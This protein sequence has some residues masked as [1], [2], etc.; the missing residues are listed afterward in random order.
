MQIKT[1]TTK[2]E[3]IK[4]PLLAIG[5]F[6]DGQNKISER[7]DKQLNNA[8]ASAVK[9]KEFTGEFLQTKLIHTLGRFSFDKLLLVG[10]GKQK[11]L[12]ISKLRRA[13]ATAALTARNTGVKQYTTNLQSI[14]LDKQIA[15][16]TC[17]VRDMV[18]QPACVMT[19]QKIADIAKTLP[20]QVK[21]T[22]HDKKALEKI[23]M[24]SIL[25]VNKGSVIEPKLIVL[26]YNFGKG[27]PIALVGKGI[28]FDSGGLDIKPA[29]GMETMKMDMAGA[30]TVL[31]TFKA[32][33]ELQLPINLVGIMPCTEN[34]PGSDAYKPGDI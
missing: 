22:I 9:Q 20:K 19:P 24:N 13:A 25:A 28:T 32:T 2:I 10:L 16:T 11:E 7:F 4:T 18:N 33:A 30:A 1:N 17:L 34:M 29:D 5:Y 12:N 23:G 31:A 14:D 6:E 27:N 3:Q 21:V 26:E 8:I 15:E